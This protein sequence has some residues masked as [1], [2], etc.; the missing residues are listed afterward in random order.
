MDIHM[1]TEVSYRNGYDRAAADLRET[2]EW[3]IID[4]SKYQCKRCKRIN[5][6]PSKFCPDCGRI[7]DK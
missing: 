4:E 1:A 2:T 6:R 7:S 5:N 3:V